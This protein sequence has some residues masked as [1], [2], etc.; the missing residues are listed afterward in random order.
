MIK[1]SPNI[2]IHGP[3]KIIYTHLQGYRVIR[4]TVE[5]RGAR[6]M[7]EGDK[8]KGDWKPLPTLMFGHL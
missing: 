1:W 2:S 6:W 7:E 8:R 4:G 5:G 3:C